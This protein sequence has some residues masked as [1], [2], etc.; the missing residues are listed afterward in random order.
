MIVITG[1]RIDTKHGRPFFC[2]ETLGTEP[3]LYIS[4]LLAILIIILVGVSVRIFQWSNNNKS[5]EVAYAVHVLK[6]RDES[7]FVN[8]SGYR[9]RINLD[10]K[11][12]ITFEFLSNRKRKMILVPLRELENMIKGELGIL[13]LQGTQCF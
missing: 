9:S 5:P 10:G 1:M 6:I 3:M 11:C 13:T 12:R 4:G 7:W 2:V 8:G